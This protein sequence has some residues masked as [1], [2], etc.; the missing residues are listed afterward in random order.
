MNKY[1][2]FCFLLDRKT[3]SLEEKFFR[4]IKKKIEKFQL[5]GRKIL[6][7]FC[8]QK[9]II[10]EISNIL[11]RNIILYYFNKFTICI[12]FFFLIENP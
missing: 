10:L 1:K 2:I 7:N 12:Y 6:Q 8:N 4:N 3:S 5:N 9:L 11:L